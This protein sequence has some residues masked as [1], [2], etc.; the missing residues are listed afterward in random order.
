MA[1]SSVGETEANDIDSLD[2]DHLDGDRT[3]YHVNN[4][5]SGVAWKLDLI[6][7]STVKMLMTS[8]EQIRQQCL[9]DTV[10]LP[11]S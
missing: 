1:E 9:K 7:T 4:A 11:T 6:N 5:T 8:T 2:S 3:I 10:V